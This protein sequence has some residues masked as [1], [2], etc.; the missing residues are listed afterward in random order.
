M[1]DLVRHLGA[2]KKQTVHCNEP[3]RF[4]SR[5]VVAELSAGSAAV[6]QSELE[7]GSG[8]FA[9]LGLRFGLL[10]TSV[11]GGGEGVRSRVALTVELAARG[12]DSV[13]SPH[14]LVTA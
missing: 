3:F 10:G 13:L 11:V 6:E 4:S 7:G 14:A 2:S 8:A 1:S 12:D 5:P 9:S